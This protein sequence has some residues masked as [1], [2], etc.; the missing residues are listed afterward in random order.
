MRTLTQFLIT[1][2]K[3]KISLYFRNQQSSTGFANYYFNEYYTII[4]KLYLQ[5]QKRRCHVRAAWPADSGRDGTQYQ[6]APGE[7]IQ[8]YNNEVGHRGSVWINTVSSKNQPHENSTAGSQGRAYGRNK[9]PGIIL[10]FSH[11]ICYNSIKERW[12]LWATITITQ[13]LLLNAGR[14]FSR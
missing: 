9:C 1:A 5:C 13:P 2:L 7:K 10:D 11:G 8:A 3:Q 6:A 4:W 12:F 14:S